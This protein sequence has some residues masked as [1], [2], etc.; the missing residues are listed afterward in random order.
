M[1]TGGAGKPGAERPPRNPGGGGNGGDTTTDSGIPDPGNI[2]GGGSGQTK[3]D[4][5]NAAANA[6]AGLTNYVLGL[7]I[8]LTG[9]VQGLISQAAS[10]GWSSDRFLLALRATPEYKNQFPG[11]TAKDGTLKMS[12]AQ[13][14]QQ[15]EQYQNIGA[16]AG[17]NVGPQKA[18]WLFQ[19]DVSPTEFSVR[20]EAMRRIR[21]NPELYRQFNRVVA[22]GKLSKKEIFQ[23]ALGMG[24]QKW[25]DVWQ[26]TISRYQARQSGLSIVKGGR[27][28]K[29]YTNVTKKLLEKVSDLGLSEA[30]MAQGFQT[31]TEHLMTTFGEAK[32]QSMG[33]TKRQLEQASFGGPRAAKI[34]Q[35]VRQVLETTAAQGED[36]AT[37][38]V[39]ESQSG[40]LQAAGKQAQAYE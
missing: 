20:A 35:R 25:Y 32:I 29:Q 39:G 31:L 12:E 34:R 23:A 7:G 3:A 13:Y 36:R 1:P 22:G 26:D 38:A 24:N 2:G 14:L 28:S 19:N 37:V 40:G 17:I 16:Q 27:Q 11:I 9:T 4:K 30:E 5:A 18:K 6:R 21:T 8:P 15:Q 33:I 10:A